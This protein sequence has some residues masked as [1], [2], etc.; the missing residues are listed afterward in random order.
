M[1]ATRPQNPISK[2]LQHFTLR[3]L[4]LFFL[5]TLIP[6]ELLKMI[7][8][9]NYLYEGM[10]LLVDWS[11]NHVFH[12]YDT[13]VFPNGSSDTSWNY[14]FLK[15]VVL[16]SLLGAFVV[17][18]IKRQANTTGH[19]RIWFLLLIRYHLI[20]ICFYY[21]IIKLFALQMPF[22]SLS[23]LATPVGE[24]HPMRMSWVFMGYSFSYQFFAGLLEVL[25][26]LLL[27]YRRTVSLGI[28]LALF[29]FGQVLLMNLSFDI[30]VKIVAGLTFLKALILFLYDSKRYVHFFLLNQS[31]TPSTLFELRLLS[32]RQKIGR[33][34]LKAVFFLLFFVGEFISVLTLSHNS[35]IDPPFKQGVYE[36]THFIQNKDT[37][38]TYK[39]E[40]AWKDMIFEY[41]GMGSVLSNDPLFRQRY[42]R[43]HFKCEKDAETNL[44]NFKTVSALREEKLI[45]S[46]QVEPLNNDGYILKGTINKKEIEIHLKN[47]N[48]TFPLSKRP[49]NWVHDYVP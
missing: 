6:W 32:K 42:G 25:A 20:M 45:F 2:L 4:F 46:M 29:V 9:L 23:L 18:L 7:P 38:D 17:T 49:F 43:G 15:L 14:T 34:V 47:K 39:D 5:F 1:E 3:F 36:V 22:P 28:L 48:K 40:R 41:D 8:G 30:P 19:L 11:N 27:F 33:I 44:V 10:V 26:G 21:G 37:L 24:L 16:L 35:P 31:T 12:T 13:L